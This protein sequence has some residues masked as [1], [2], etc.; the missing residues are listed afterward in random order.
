MSPF[1]R[2]V[3]LSSGA[4]CPLTGVSGCFGLLA[5]HL[6][7]AVTRHLVHALRELCLG[8]QISTDLMEGLREHGLIGVNEQ[9]DVVM[10]AVVLA[11]V[12]GEGHNLYLVSPFTDSWDRQLSEFLDARDRIRVVLPDEADRILAEKDPLARGAMHYLDR[13]I[14]SGDDWT[15]RLKGSGRVPNGPGGNSP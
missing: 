5:S 9:F 11:A 10:K 15:S 8:R 2:D 14:R 6:E 12:R 4:I 7:D 3:V 1:R 13:G